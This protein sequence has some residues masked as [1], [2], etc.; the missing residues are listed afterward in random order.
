[1][2]ISAAEH[3]NEI[4][5]LREEYLDSIKESQE[6][7][8]EFLV[9]SGD[10][11]LLQDRIGVTLGYFITFHQNILVEFYVRKEYV[12][13]CESIFRFVVHRQKIK[14]VFCKSFDSILL[15]C[16]LGQF[17]NHKL[18]GVL[19]RNLD[20]VNNINLTI[21]IRNPSMSD[22]EAISKVKEGLFDDDQE[23]KQYIENKNMLVYEKDGAFIGCGIFQR[24]NE[25]RRYFD[26]GMLV[27]PAHRK[28]G[29]GAEIITSLVTFCHSNN[30]M[31]V[32]GCA[33][34]NIASRKTLEKAGFISFH[35]LIEFSNF[36]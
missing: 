16:S 30:W 34:E 15:K 32:C 4:T 9:D 8:V 11:F 1:M 28:Q 13:R 12:S 25:N 18:I 10:Y 22:F 29:Y 3:Y 21:E 36:S 20:P 17:S 19:F 6:L 26:I 23:I 5:D 24:I 2:K 33:V 31:P 14:R 27:H 35:D 7:Y